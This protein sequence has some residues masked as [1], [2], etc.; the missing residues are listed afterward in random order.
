MNSWFLPGD[1]RIYSQGW[2]HASK[3]CENIQYASTLLRDGDHLLVAYG[4][5]DCDSYVQQFLLSDILHS[6]VNVSDEI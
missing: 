6:M 3:D 2:L 5:E 1:S 4:V